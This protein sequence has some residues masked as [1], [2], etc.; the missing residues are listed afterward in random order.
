MARSVE[1]ERIT[2]ETEIH[3]QLDLNG[4]GQTIDTGVPFLDHL[5]EAMSFHGNMGLTLRAS[6]DVERDPHHLVED[7]G[8]SLGLALGKTIREYGHVTRF[9]RE[10]VPMDDALGEAVIDAGGRP[11]LVYRA[12]FPQP[13]CG[14]FHTALLREFYLGVV[15]GGR[16][17][18]HLIGHYAENSHHLAEA[19]F[20]AFGRALHQAYTLRGHELPASTK[21]TLDEIDQ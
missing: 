13:Y 19:L 7:V 16:I 9:G 12:E 17:N 4:G 20:K 2:K 18:L 6:G 1:I 15:N 14:T 11:Y 3:L 8:I 10:A 5:L 21:G